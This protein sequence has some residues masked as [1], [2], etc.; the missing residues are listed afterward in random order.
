MTE[1]QAEIEDI[2]RFYVD[3]CKQLRE[4]EQRFSDLE[5]DY[6]GIMEERRIQVHPSPFTSLGNCHNPS[7]PTPLSLDSTL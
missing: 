5:T 2:Q 4:L 7:F 1:K 6:N 3:E